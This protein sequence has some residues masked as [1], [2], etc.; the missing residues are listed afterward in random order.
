MV[1]MQ[2]VPYGEIENLSGIGKIRKLLNITK[3]DKIVLLQGRLSK[4]EEAE[5]I[6]VT[7]EEINEEFRGIELA[8]IDTNET[9][10]VTGFAKIKND[11]M[12]SILGDRHG[13]TVIGPA[14]VIKNIKREPSKIELFTKEVKKKS[15]HKKR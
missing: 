15:T 2:V 11:I 9:S 4:D 1:T 3:E 6:K 5:L 10:S 7:M 13:F 8:V 12:N 14:S